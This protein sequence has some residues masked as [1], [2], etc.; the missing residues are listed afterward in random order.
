MT[1]PQSAPDWGPKPM[2]TAYFSSYQ[3]WLGDADQGMRFK[4]LGEGDNWLS[5]LHSASGASPFPAWSGVPV[6]PS[7]T[8]TNVGGMTCGSTCK[9]YSGGVRIRKGGVSTNV[10]AFRGAK[11][12]LSST[13]GLAFKFELLLT[14]CVRLNTSS[15]FGDSGRYF[16]YSHSNQLPGNPPTSEPTQLAKEFLDSGVKVVNVHQ[17]VPVLNPFI[18]Y[19]FA[20]AA[21]GPLSTLTQGLHEGGARMKLYYTTRELSNHVAEMWMLRALGAEVLDPGSADTNHA[22][23]NVGGGSGGASWLQE[24]LRSNY[25]VCWST[26]PDGGAPALAKYGMIDAG[27]CD[28]QA[29]DLHQRWSNYYVAG[30]DWLVSEPPHMDGLYLDGIA[31][32]AQTMKRCRK[33]MDA[34]KDKQAGSESALIDLHSGNNFAPAYGMISPAL[35]YMMLLPYMD[36]TM[37]GEG[38]QP[39]YDRPAGTQ[40]V[41]N[42]GGPDWWLVE[43]SAIPFGLMNDMLGNGQRWRGW[44]FG[45]VTRLPYGG[46]S[47]NKAD[48]A[49]WDRYKL[50]EATMF[51]WWWKQTVPPVRVVAPVGADATTAAA[52]TTTVDRTGH[53]LATAYVLKDVHSLVSVASWANHSI[54]CDLLVDWSRLGLT[55]P[56]QVQAHAIDLF[57]GNA[58][59]SV[60]GKRVKN[61]P[62]APARGWLL[63]LGTYIEPPPGPPPRPPLPAPPPPAPPA[64]PP[65]PPWIPGTPFT[66]ENISIGAPGSGTYCSG[67]GECLF[68]KTF[69]K[70]MFGQCGILVQ[71]VES[72]CGTWSECAGAI[73]RPGYNGYCLAR[74][75][76]TDAVAAKDAWGYRKVPRK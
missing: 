4:L 76:M 8:P 66:W 54:T 45:C 64:P 47:T 38:Y 12:S 27:V 44:L 35:Q 51:G 23:R 15:H 67:G 37:F 29:N 74:R 21:T 57:Q 1:E 70:P 7:P 22:Y 61:V 34:A 43:V 18:N 26:P 11:A 31:Y 19:P 49:L 55:P 60:Q 24:H 46:G 41:S 2:T 69:C 40:V 28:S 39:G 33:V 62:T 75:E 48:W 10:T 53:I 20:P 50:T 30:L 17:G 71:E 36:S 9:V 3:V 6:P 58:T 42:R 72:K 5:A 16:Q 65:P 63:V 52:C 25:S 73:C 14:P 59:F 32:N 68:N 13:M 56:T